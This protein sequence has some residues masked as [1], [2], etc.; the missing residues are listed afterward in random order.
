LG[1]YTHTNILPMSAMPAGG[2]CSDTA[3][4][5]NCMC[6]FPNIGSLRFMVHCA[7]GSQILPSIYQRSFGEVD[8]V[9]GSNNAPRNAEWW[10]T[11][12]HR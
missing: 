3:L 12:G 2:P 8:L 7:S 9:T 11:N 5:R 6:C 4:Q 10:F 1:G